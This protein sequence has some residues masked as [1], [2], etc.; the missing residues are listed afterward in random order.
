MSE[1]DVNFKMLTPRGVPLVV[2][3]KKSEG[4]HSHTMEVRAWG[5]NDTPPAS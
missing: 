5:H 2:E 3:Y 4:S 1:L